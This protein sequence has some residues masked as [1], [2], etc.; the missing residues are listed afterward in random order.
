MGVRFTPVG[1]W[2][3]QDRLKEAGLE[4]DECY[5]FDCEETERPHLA[6]EV[7]WTSGGIDKLKVYRRLGVEEVWYWRKGQ[8]RVY[9]LAQEGYRAQA[10]SARLPGLDLELLVSFLDRPSAYDTI[11]GFRSALR[12]D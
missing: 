8:L 5:V 6:I 11:Q 12:K 1:S 3:L 10:H 9:V 4:P 2:T 7:V